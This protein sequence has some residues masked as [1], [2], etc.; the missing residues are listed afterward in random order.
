MVFMQRQRMKDVLLQGLAVAR[1][2]N[3]QFSFSILRHYCTK[4]RAARHHSTNQIIDFWRGRYRC[5]RQILNSQI[6]PVKLVYS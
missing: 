5:R 4:K 1:T 2:S 6:L 3:M